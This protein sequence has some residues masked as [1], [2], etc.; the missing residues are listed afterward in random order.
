MRHVLKE[1]CVPFD[2]ARIILSA[3]DSRA[4]KSLS[5]LPLMVCNQLDSLFQIRR[6]INKR[7]ARPRP[8]DAATA[9]QNLASK[10]SALEREARDLSLSAATASHHSQAEVSASSSSASSFSNP[11]SSTSTLSSASA[12]SSSSSSSPSSSALPPPLDPLSSEA[13]LNVHERWAALHK[14]AHRSM[15]A[16]DSLRVFEAFQKVRGVCMDS[17]FFLFRFGTSL[18]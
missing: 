11:S 9:V 10:I 5:H 14:A 1:Q 7:H 15:R 3:D 4:C 6:F 18:L 16:A 8:I 2:L 12:S 13:A 17:I